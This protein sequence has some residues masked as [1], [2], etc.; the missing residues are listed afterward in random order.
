MGMFDTTGADFSAAT[1]KEN[2]L[3]KLDR[4]KK[5]LRHEEPDRVPISDFFWG[6]FIRRWRTELGLPDDANPYYYYDL[7]WIATVPNMDPWIRS[8][9]TLKETSEEVVVKTGL[10]RDPA[11]EIRLPH[12]RVHRL[13]DRHAGKA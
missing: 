3:R 2:T 4:L 12:A 11:E 9:E 5:T 7:D 6:G 8:F 13:G 10:R 1:R